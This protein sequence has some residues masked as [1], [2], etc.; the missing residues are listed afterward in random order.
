[1]NLYRS[2]LATIGPEN[3]APRVV[4]SDC[5]SSSSPAVVGDMPCTIWRKSGRNVIEVKA[6]TPPMKLTTLTRVNALL[7]KS[8]GGISAS[9]PMRRSTSR[10]HTRPDPPSA[11][12]PSESADVHPHSLP[13]SATSNSGTRPTTRAVAP[14]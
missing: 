10:N 5:G 13:C 14:Q 6:P 4:A 12:S 2:V 1:M 3:L 11:N 8:R 9:S 7:A